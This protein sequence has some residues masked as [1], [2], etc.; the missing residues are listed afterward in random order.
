MPTLNKS[1]FGILY[2]GDIYQ[3]Q[4]P[5]FGL[6][7]HHFQQL[8]RLA[9]NYGL[10]VI[11][12][13]ALGTDLTAKKI[14]GFYLSSQQQWVLTEVPLPQVI[15]VRGISSA[16]HENLERY[17][18][19]DRFEKMQI[20]L[21]NNNTF[22]EFVGDKLS[23]DRFLR[24]TPLSSYLPETEEFTLQ[25][26]KPFCDRHPVTFL[27]PV[28]GYESRGLIRIEYEHEIINIDFSDDQG[29]LQKLQGTF[30]QLL[31][32]VLTFI[33]AR[34]YIMQEGVPR[35]LIQNRLIEHR[36]LYQRV[37]EQ[38][39]QTTHVLRMNSAQNLPFITAGREKNVLFDESPLNLEISDKNAF[40][41]EIESLAQ[42]LCVLFNQS[43]RHASEFSMDLIVNLNQ[44]IKLLE[45][46]AKPSGF[47]L[48]TGNWQGRMLYLSRTLKQA[49]FLKNNFSMSLTKSAL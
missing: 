49:Q 34:S 39:F 24:Q 13:A 37:G 42:K 22:S 8:A 48:Q 40:E 29:T 1:I 32:E 31:P 44:E 20:P 12:F 14:R 26:F 18:I 6:E 21:I 7:D 15:Y 2:F 23:F 36:C 5:F 27:K 10:Q 35:K 41:R 9:P 28:D 43:P 45:C 16:P 46:N 33:Q 11:V 17:Q 30:E 19:V 47:F 3:N 38:W 25:T 4:P